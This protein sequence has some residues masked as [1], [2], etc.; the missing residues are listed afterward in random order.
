MSINVYLK[1]DE[2]QK[3]EGFTTKKR[4]GGKPVQEW[5]EHELSGVKLSHDKGRWYIYLGELTDPIPAVVE[6][7][8]EEI[9]LRE[10]LKGGVRRETGIYRYQ[11]AEAEIDA[12]SA[13][14]KPLYM[15]RIRAQKMEDLL[16]L[17]RKIKIGSIR[18]EE[19]YEGQ[20]NG[21]SRVELEAELKRVQEENEGFRGMLNLAQRTFD[22]AEKNFHNACNK[23]VKFRKFAIELSKEMWPICSKERVTRAINGVLDSNV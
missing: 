23:N 11:S 8:V 6:N 2:V 18:P 20:Q 1:G 14:G 16:E 13:D 10:Y 3:L 5:D 7:I 22:D 21:R 17:F 15:V 9:S 12:A 4:Q 19:S